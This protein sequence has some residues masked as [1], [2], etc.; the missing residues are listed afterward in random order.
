M[1]CFKIADRLVGNGQPA[2]IIAEI[3]N[4]HNGDFDM[5]IELVD[6][7]IDCKADAVKFQVKDI[8]TAFPKEL[9]D[10][11]YQG[12]NSFGKTYREHKQA[13]EFSHEQYAEIK[14]YCDKKGI[15]FL[16]TPF[17]LPS[18]E[19]LISLD[20]PAY[21]IASF[22]LVDENLLRA[23]C[24]S[25][26]P[27]IVST[28]MSTAE[29]IDRAVAIM[30]EEKAEFALLQCT[31]SYPTKDEDVHLSVI[32]ELFKRY[33]CVVGYSGHDKGITIPASSVCFGAKIIEKHFTLDHTLK[34]PDHAASLEPKGLAGLVERTRLLERA[35]GSPE[36]HV[37][38]CE[39][40][41]RM[42]NRGY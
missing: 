37:L 41:N 42:K 40:K 6:R 7:A 20:L 21:K 5:A 31:S 36:K 12:P 4:N 17:D 19:F 32:P 16:C 28:G 14:R 1:P 2:Y 33:N 24:K 9:L 11:P 34:G 15:P 22:H 27:L 18:L 38:E 35:I 3:G 10:S 23:T 26:K 39:M 13:L 30:R 8:E 29:E 25:G